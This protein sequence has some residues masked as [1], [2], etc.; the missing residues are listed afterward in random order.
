MVNYGFDVGINLSH[1]HAHTTKKECTINHMI[2]VHLCI[3]RAHRKVIDKI[4]S[5]CCWVRLLKIFKRS[6][7]VQNA[8]TEWKKRSLRRGTEK[9]LKRKRGNFWENPSKNLVRSLF[10]RSE[11]CWMK[12]VFSISC[13]SIV[14]GTRK[15]RSRESQREN[16]SL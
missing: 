13:H 5:L 15:F 9:K 1:L 7:N 6:K 4:P 3:F 11:S 10:L 16:R 12:K 2:D 8:V 14:N